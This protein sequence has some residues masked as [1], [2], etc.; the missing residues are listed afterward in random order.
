[1]ADTE[2]GENPTDIDRSEANDEPSDLLPTKLLLVP[3]KPDEV[4][5]AGGDGQG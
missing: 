5:E 4:G 3:A 1:L 2:P